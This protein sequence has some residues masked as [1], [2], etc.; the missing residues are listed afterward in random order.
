MIDTQAMSRLV[1][2]AVAKVM[3]QYA[4]PHREYMTINE[5]CEEL[6]MSRWTVD[7]HIRVNGMPH[8]KVEK[9]VLIERTA[10][11]EWLD[12]QQK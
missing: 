6:H 9:R 4:K 2:D 7:K 1:E 3:Q 8:V 12:Q 11:Y 10:L 5:V